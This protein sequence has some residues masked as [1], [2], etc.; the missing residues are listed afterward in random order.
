M[1][2]FSFI[3]IFFY[4]FLAVYTDFSFLLKEAEIYNH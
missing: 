1:V 4:L 3:Y 2:R